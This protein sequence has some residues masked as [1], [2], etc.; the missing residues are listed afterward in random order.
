MPQYHLINMPKPKN[1]VTMKPLFSNSTHVVY[2]KPGSL[3]SG[4]G[5]V[6]NSSHKSK[7]T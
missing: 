7:N 5:T 1:G 2:Y 4:V 3:S 6:R